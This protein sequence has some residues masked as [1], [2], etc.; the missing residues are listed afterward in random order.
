M[1]T[2]V[3]KGNFQINLVTIKDRSNKTLI[4]LH[5]LNTAGTA[6]NILLLRRFFFIQ[7]SIYSFGQTTV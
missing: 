4:H 6:G 1:Y 2:Q 3:K 5:N 7:V